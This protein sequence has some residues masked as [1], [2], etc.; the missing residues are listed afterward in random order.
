MLALALSC[1]EW[2]RLAM[3]PARVQPSQHIAGSQYVPPV[4]LAAGQRN[5]VTRPDTCSRKGVSWYCDGWACSSVKVGSDVCCSCGAPG[6]A[7]EHLIN[8]QANSLAKYL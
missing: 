6:V 2:A 8:K 7:G 5:G 4:W 3:L 1:Q